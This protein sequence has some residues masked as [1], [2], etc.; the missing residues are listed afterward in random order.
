[1]EGK[2][3]LSVVNA[4]CF[5]RI[6]HINDYILSWFINV[7]NYSTAQISFSSSFPSIYKIY[8]SSIMGHCFTKNNMESIQIRG[9][10]HL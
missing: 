9:R 3:M 10:I 6:P 4:D 1:M 5:L 7:A 8:S 2:T